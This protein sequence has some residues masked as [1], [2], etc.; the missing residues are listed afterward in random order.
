MWNGM[1]AIMELFGVM[2]PHSGTV[3]CYYTE[4]GVGLLTDLIEP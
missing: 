2:I 3:K 4:R 1:L